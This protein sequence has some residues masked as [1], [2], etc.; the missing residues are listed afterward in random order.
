VCKAFA[1]GMEGGIGLGIAVTRTPFFEVLMLCNAAAVKCHGLGTINS[2][3]YRE[4]LMII[5]CQ[6][7]VDLKGIV[8]ARTEHKRDA[9]A[10]MGRRIPIHNNVNINLLCTTRTYSNCIINHVDTCQDCHYSNQNIC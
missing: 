5:A 6:Y 3:N 2:C 9:C 1:L 10:S 4:S 7:V 8:L